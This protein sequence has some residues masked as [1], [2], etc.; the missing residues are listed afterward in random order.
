MGSEGEGE[1]RAGGGVAGEV[2]REAVVIRGLE[3]EGCWRTEVAAMRWRAQERARMQGQTSS[4]DIHWDVMG[5]IVTMIIVITIV[6]LEVVGV[7]AAVVRFC[8]ITVQIRL[9]LW[10]SL[11][12]VLVVPPGSGSL[13]GRSVCERPTLWTVL[14]WIRLV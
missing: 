12:V 2:V 9:Q 7:E 8:I 6:T 13:L 1:K 3:V 5:L 10:L 14:A 4:E 11:L